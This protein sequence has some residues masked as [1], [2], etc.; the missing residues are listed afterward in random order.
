MPLDD[1]HWTKLARELRRAAARVAPAW[2][3]ANADDPGFTLLEL[4]AYALD[5]LAYRSGSLSADARALTEGVA[6]RATALASAAGASSTDACGAGLRRPR[7]FA[8]QLL[9]ASDLD[10]E[11][12]YVLA[13]L[14]RLNRLLHGIGIVDGLGVAVETGA[15]APQV[16]IEPGLAFDPHGREIFLDRCQRLALPGS[17]TALLV[18]LSYREQPCTSVPAPADAPAP[19][20]DGEATTRPTR[21]V[22]AFDATLAATV[23]EGSVAVARVHRVRGRWRVDPAFEAARVRR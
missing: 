23:S 18:Q 6:R 2:T 22:E 8:G 19:G 13:R 14:G 15:D 10:A 11:Q 3:D 7:Y 4:L 21:I 9:D 12:D 20:I 5:E 16:V 1:E 17:G